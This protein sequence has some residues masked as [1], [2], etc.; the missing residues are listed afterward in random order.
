MPY[1]YIYKNDSSDLFELQYRNNPLKSRYTIELQVSYQQLRGGFNLR[2]LKFISFLSLIFIFL[3]FGFHLLIFEG[4][5]WKRVLNLNSIQLTVGLLSTYW[6]F[7]TFRRAAKMDQPFWLFLSGGTFFS[8]FGTFIWIVIMLRSHTVQ[9]PVFSSVLWICAYFLYF[10]AL[11]FKLRKDST[12]LANTT[13]FFNMAIYMV[14]AS[15]ISYFY[16][17]HPLYHLQKESF[18]LNTITILFQFADLGILFFIVTVGYLIPFDRKN[19]TL[20]FL[21]IGLF[22]QVVGDVIFAQLTIE[23]TYEAG[24]LVDFMWTLALLFIGFTGLYYA[25]TQS[26]HTLKVKRPFFKREF[27]LPY[28]IIL[29]LSFLMI[30]SYEWHLNALSIGWFTIFTLILIRQTLVLIKNKRLLTELEDVAYRDRLTG[31]G[32]QA[33]FIRSTPELKQYP[34]A[35]IAVVV[36]HLDRFKQFMDAFGYHVGNQ[37]IQVMS[38]RLSVIL[39]KGVRVFRTSEN[40]FTVLLPYEKV[41]MLHERCNEL[42]AFLRTTMKIEYH[43]ISLVPRIG[44]SLYPVHSDDLEELQRLASEALYHSQNRTHHLYTFYDASFTS[45]LAQHLEMETHLRNALQSNQF[46]VYY[47]PKVHLSTE[48]IVGMEA[49]IRWKHPD[50]GFISPAEFIPIAEESGLINDIGEWVLRTA[51]MYNKKLQTLGFTPLLL[52]VNV[53]SLQFQNPLFSEKV[54]TI[55]KET[56]LDAQ[57]LELEITESIV[58]DIEESISILQD[59][60]RLG[61]ETSIDDFGTGY[62]SLNVL[63]QLPIDTLK[64]DKSFVDRLEGDSSSPIVKTIIELGM[65]LKLSIVAEGIETLQQKKIL[66]QY[67]CPIGQ[68]YFFSPPVEAQAF[69]ALL[70]V[71]ETMVLTQ[72]SH[73]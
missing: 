72:I 47:Q 65:N 29:L 63:E 35:S 24:K 54:E 1:F 49:L 2:N 44:I 6:L 27:L 46:E 12:I 67:G 43:E 38:S 68:G 33:D 48:S 52:S 37:I 21:V 42:I 20:I 4:P 59:L 62:S 23:N 14:A 61:V 7:K 58:Q 30:K 39:P 50:F 15:S 41:E 45:R 3:S 70:P 32:N 36:V 69:M 51:C 34:D 66:E 57:W 53:S 64:I 9:T 73:H 16:L 22:L 11:I 60:A 26:Q 5:S 17:L 8:A 18:W 28:T 31:I 56:G 25:P 10:S 13:Y 19:H 40:E 55:L 71:Q